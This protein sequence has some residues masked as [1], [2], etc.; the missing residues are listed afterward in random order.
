[1]ENSMGSFRVGALALMLATV[2]ALAIVSTA[3]LAQEVKPATGSLTIAFA[4]EASSLDPATRVGVDEYFL[5]QIYEQLVRPDPNLERQNWLAEKWVLKE[6]NGKPYLD[7][8]LRKGVKFH[9]GDEMI[10][11]DFQFAF[12]RLRN[13]KTARQPQLQAEVEAFEIV[14]DYHFRIRFKRGDGSYISDNLQLWAMSKKYHDKV[15]DEGFV[16]HPVGT[17]PWKFVSRVVKEELKLEAFDD[18]WNKEFRP[19]V[20]NLTVKIIPEDMTRVAAFKTGAVDWID[21][22]PP[23]MVEEFKK[24]PGVVTQSFVTPNNLYIAMDETAEKSP[25]KDVRVRR[26]LAHAIDIDAIIKNVLFGQGERYTEVGK[27]TT[28]YDPDLKPY[29][30]DPAKARSLLREAGYPNGFEVPCYNLTTPR[31]PYIKEVGEAIFAY[32]TAAGIRCR[33]Q[34]M[35]YGAWLLRGRRAGETTPMGGLYST[36]WPHGLPGD[37]ATPW[38]GHL[39]SFMPTGG[40]GSA[41]YGSDP[42]IDRMVEELKQTMDPGK[43]GDIIKKIARLKHDRV[44]GGLTTY[45]PVATFAWRDKVAFRAWPVPGFWHSMQQIGLKQ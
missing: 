19:T 43:R 37:P 36:M 3:A 44:T 39:H 13:P 28:G 42:E 8:H 45:R 31:E 7:I 41:A 10:S 40:W 38:S 14:D 4:A 18:Y 9:T 22:V 24:M 26:A 35:E 21:A 32:A 17:G 5:G 27:G 33:V 1:M 12:E 20:K 30:F 15:G 23:S 11:A 29:P 16:K 25:F 34:G 2:S 6:E